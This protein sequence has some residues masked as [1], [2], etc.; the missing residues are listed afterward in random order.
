MIKSEH[1][2]EIRRLYVRGIL[3][4]AVYCVLAY[5]VLRQL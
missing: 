5:F 2:R 3:M 4:L 1:R